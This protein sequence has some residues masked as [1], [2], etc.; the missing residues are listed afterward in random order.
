MDVDAGPGGQGV[1]QGRVRKA[2]G[3]NGQ[4]LHSSTK[5]KIQIKA[6]MEQHEVSDRVT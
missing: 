1:R 2:P 6:L 4:K 5:T 3:A